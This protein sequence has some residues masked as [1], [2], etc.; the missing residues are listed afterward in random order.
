MKKKPLSGKYAT[1]GLLCS[2]AG[3]N[4]DVGNAASTAPLPLF[5]KSLTLSWQTSRVERHL[6]SGQTRQFG[7]SATL[8]VYVSTQGRLFTEKTGVALGPSTRG[9]QR[10]QEVSDSPERRE[11]R[12]WRVE[13]RSLVAYHEFRSGVRRVVVDFDKDYRTCSLKVSFAKLGGTENIVR[14]N[15]WEIQSIEVSS[16]TCRVQAGNIFE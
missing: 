16:P 11:V 15:G 2:L 13:E 5:G 3:V 12:E 14:G 6:M 8:R 9:G 7:A 10:H 4:P 1:I